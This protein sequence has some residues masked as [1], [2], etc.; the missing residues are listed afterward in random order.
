MKVDP[1]VKGGVTQ[2]TKL[3]QLAR[4][5]PPKRER[6]LQLLA[7]IEGLTSSALNTSL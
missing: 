1:A 5:T 3:L 7:R 4:V 6:E 2:A